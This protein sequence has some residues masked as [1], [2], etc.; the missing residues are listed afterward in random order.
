VNPEKNN[1]ESGSSPFPKTSPVGIVLS[2]LF[3]VMVLAGIYYRVRP[4]GPARKDI[5]LTR[6]YMDTY[7]EIIVISRDKMKARKAREEAFDCFERLEKKFNFYDSGSL[8]QH[9]NKEISSPIKDEDFLRLLSR[10][11]EFSRE[12]GGAFDMTLGAVK[13]LYPIGKENPAPPKDEEIEDALAV[14]GYKKVII[15]GNRFSRPEGLLID[16]G[17]ILKGYAVDSAI[18]ILRKRGIKDALVNAGGN[19]RA[20]G[21]NAEGEPWNIGVENPR[22]PGNIMAVI[23]LDNQAVAS[24]GDY[25]R[26]FFY[27]K[28]RYH[29]IINPETGKPADSAISATVIGPDALTCD[30]LS[31]AVF[32]MGKKR[33]I[34][35]LERHKLQGLVVDEN[36]VELTSGLKGKIKVEYSSR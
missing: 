26:Y 4:P 8:L 22:A 25:Q 21:R 16:A 9:V 2:S 14:S 27:D 23:S 10:G 6:F 1:K 31:T 28:K 29:H 19:I 32:V 36:G 35:F 20:F 12:T 34:E 30:A 18:D 5:H 3:M 11:F 24:S 13:K 33:G 7:V 17:G 15:S